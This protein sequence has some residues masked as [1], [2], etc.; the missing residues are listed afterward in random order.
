MVDLTYHSGFSDRSLVNYTFNRDGKLHLLFLVDQRSIY[1]FIESHAKMANTYDEIR[2]NI[3]LTQIKYHVIIMLKH[4]WFC[5]MFVTRVFVTWMSCAFVFKMKKQFYKIFSWISCFHE[6]L[7]KHE[8]HEIHGFHGFC[9][10]N[11]KVP[12]SIVLILSVHLRY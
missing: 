9:E 8:K 7:G 3:D 12:M 2:W 4:T 1:Q 10:F 6:V 11:E 5:H